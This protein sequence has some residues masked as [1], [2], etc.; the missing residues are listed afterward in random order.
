MTERTL[1]I[2]LEAHIEQP[3]LN[4]QWE[5]EV[6]VPVPP[7]YVEQDIEPFVRHELERA[8]TT[9]E[10]EQLGEARAAAFLEAYDLKMRVLRF[11]LITAPRERAVLQL[12]ARIRELIELSNDDLHAQWGHFETEG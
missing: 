7:D 5:H 3:G 8:V 11:L 10:R 6:E 2:Q 4:P 12:A 1:H 9:L